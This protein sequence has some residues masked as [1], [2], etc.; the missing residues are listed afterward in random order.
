MAKTTH[1]VN[2]KGMT[3]LGSQELNFKQSSKIR[4]EFDDKARH[5]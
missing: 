5:E 1:S 4:A 2:G 3:N